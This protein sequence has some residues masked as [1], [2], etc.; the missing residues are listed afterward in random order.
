MR[1]RILS[2]SVIALG[3]GKADLLDA[4]ASTGSISGAARK[5]GMSYRRAWILVNTMNACFA[6]PVVGTEKGGAEGGGAE[7]TSTGRRV[8]KQ[9]R[10]LATTVQSTFGPLLRVPDTSGR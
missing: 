9:Y 6:E 4:I 3:P 5:M 2:E 10:R 7:L 8:L 1:V